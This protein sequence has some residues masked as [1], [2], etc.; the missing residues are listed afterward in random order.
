MAQRPDLW[1]RRWR[2]LRLAVLLR[3]G[4]ECQGKGCGKLLGYAEVD[5]IKPVH[6]GG[7]P[8]DLANLQTLCRD[9]HQRKTAEELG[10]SPDREREAWAA[11][12]RNR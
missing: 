11:Y 7:L 4:R 12:L 2:R 6:L 5:H 8:F 3:D 1:T 10:H 9:C